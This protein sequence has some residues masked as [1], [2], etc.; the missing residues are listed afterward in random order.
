MFPLKL[1]SKSKISV[2]FRSRFNS[3]EALV[4]RVGTFVEIFGC[5]LT[6]LVKVYKKDS[7]IS[8]LE[9][10]KSRGATFQ[11]FT[12]WLTR[13]V[14]TL[15]LKLVPRGKGKVIKVVRWPDKS[16]VIR[17][18]V[19]K[20]C[21]NCLPKSP[22]GF[23]DALTLSQKHGGLFLNKFSHFVCKTI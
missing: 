19:E 1:M 4:S 10:K 5:I 23:I 12:A 13:L 7:R 11:R 9:S 3:L 14:M 21:N 17:K 8:Q 18:H 15:G 22:P 16:L 20:W 6:F 2:A